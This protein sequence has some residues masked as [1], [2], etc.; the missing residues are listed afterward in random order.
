MATFVLVPGMWLGGWVWRDVAERLRAAGHSVYP[1]TLT[2]LGERSH[3]GG[4]Q[5]TLDTHIADIV[6]LLS[7]EDLHDV[8]LV[9]HSYA[10]NPVAGVAQQA[11]ARIA[12]IV[13]VDTWPLPAG[14][15]QADLLSPEARAAQDKHLAEQGDGWRVPMWSW[16]DLDQGNDLRDLGAAERAFI[17]ARATDHPVGS[18][19]QPMPPVP[20]GF[21][22]PPRTAI[23]CSL[24]IE[25]VAGMV[26]AYPQI[27]STL[28]EPGWEQIELPT[29]HWPMVSRPR[30]LAD[31]LA[32]L[33]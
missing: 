32:G 1:V 17:G 19:T 14:V 20:D 6:N 23:W 7:F 28:A 27:T 4:T 25:D 10:A 11:A 2:G 16:Q 12:R 3:L 9:G 26:A 24:T 21:V 15:A 22:S 18:T 8:L 30:E 13:Y 33:A 29:G 31:L 5:V